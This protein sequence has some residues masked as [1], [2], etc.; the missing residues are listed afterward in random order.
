LSDVHIE[1]DPNAGQG[2]VVIDGHNIRGS[3]EGFTLQ[4]SANP[5]SRPRLVIA[6]R[7]ADCTTF[8]A[9]HVQVLIGDESAGLLERAGWT[10]P[11]GVR[12][13]LDRD[14]DGCPCE[15]REGNRVGNKAELLLGRTVPTCPVHGVREGGGA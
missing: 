4:A 1:L 11:P 8:E 13:V 15:W 5:G 14:A 12:S 3:I 10:P 7:A 6:L 9:P 2:M